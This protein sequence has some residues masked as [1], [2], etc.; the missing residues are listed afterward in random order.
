MATPRSRQ[1]LRPGSRREAGGA[2]TAVS[3]RRRSSLGSGVG[4]GVGSGVGGTARV[5]MG[6]IPMNMGGREVVDLRDSLA[7]QDIPGRTRGPNRVIQ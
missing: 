5:L 2:S 6:P 4:G 7:C 1:A 3:C